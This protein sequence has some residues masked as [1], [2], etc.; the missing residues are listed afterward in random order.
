MRHCQFSY[1]V[2]PCAKGVLRLGW[3]Q[4]HLKWV[5]LLT[6]CSIHAAHIDNFALM[7]KHALCQFQ[8]L[9]HRHFLPSS[10]SLHLACLCLIL[11]YVCF[12]NGL[13]P[14]ESF[15]DVAIIPF[16]TRGW[17]KTEWWILFG[18]S[19]LPFSPVFPTPPTFAVSFAFGK[20]RAQF[21][22]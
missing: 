22:S 4:I 5:P 2:K 1:L 8:F 20:M 7:A 10:S 9:N 19:L 12:W 6:E 13:P 15:R 21:N 16:P 18:L 14:V 17:N 11:C 3:R